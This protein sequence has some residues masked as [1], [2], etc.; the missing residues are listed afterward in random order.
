M[1]DLRYQKK[2][3][4][5]LVAISER[6]ISD[7]D[8]KLIIFQA[9]TGSGK[10]IML[11]SALSNI[12]KDLQNKKSLAFLWISVNYLHEQ[13]KE[14][15]E[16]YFE[17]ER[18][19]ECVSTN[20]IQN[21]VIEENQIVFVNWESL[22]RKGNIFMV[23]NEKDWNLSKVVENSKDEDREVVLIIDES[24][25][26]A[27]TSKAKEIINIIN[28]KLTIEVSATPK[29]GI[30][31]DHRVNVKL[32]KVIDEEMIK[33][34]IQ[35]NSGLARAE[36]N[37]DIINAA[38]RRRKRLQKQFQSA[39]TNI[40]PLLLIQIPRKKSSDVRNPEDKIIELLDKRGVTTDKGKLAI[41]LS[42]K[43]KKINLE[44]LEKNDSDVD[45]LVF[46]EAIALGWDCP[47][48]SLLLLQREWNA[49]NYVFNIQTLGR[50]MRMPEHKHYDNYPD[51]NIGY[52][53]TASDNFS[54]VE[55]LANDYVSRVQMLRDNTI[56]GNIYLPSEHIRRKREKYR[57][58]GDF[59]ECL[60]KAGKEQK[61]K[62]K[63]NTGV[64]KFKKKI[65][66][67]GY[68]EKIDQ[69][70]TIP[71]K[72]KSEIEKDREEVC[73]WYTD[74][75][76]SKTYPFTGGSRP[77]T[78][79]KSSLRALFKKVFGISNEDK[80]GMIVLNPKNKGEFEQLID[81]AKEK[82]KHLPEKKDIVNI[83]ED[84][85]VPEAISIFDNY[86]KM[87]IDNKYIKKSV[88]KPF[89][90][91]KDKNKKLRCSKPEREFIKNLEETDDDVLW[92]LK[93]GE[94]ES[95]YFGIAY[96]KDDSHYYG[97]YPDFIIQTK[98]ETLVVEIKD[99]KDFKNENL[100]KLN[101][102]KDF[103][104]KHK[105]KNLYFFIISPIDYFNF[106]RALKVQDLNS[107][108]SKYEENLLRFAQ[109]RKI[110]SIQQEEKNLEDKELLELYDDELSKAI[111]NIDDKKLE[112]EILK[113]DLENAEVTIDNLKTSLAYRPKIKDK[114]KMA[115]INI[116]KPFN[117]C[118]LGET[119][120]ND[121]V[122][123]EL[124]KYFAKYGLK[125]TEWN[126]NFYN[127]TKLKNTKVLDKLKK[128]QSKFN[129]IITGQIYFH[130]GKGNKKANLLTE[131]KK[132]KY[133]D[134]IVGCSPKKLLTINDIIKNLEEYF[135]T[136]N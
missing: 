135:I 36:N 116:P 6:Y 126:V 112:N 17:D 43:D 45:V 9:P 39:K 30:T 101:A 82:Y 3:I 10:T 121:F 2:A 44:Y 27:K 14:K 1:K 42:E 125:V 108:K 63:I 129:L 102:G 124:R 115:G 8:P 40:N 32:T 15:L 65:G 66:V 81:I 37:E 18:L 91:K 88:L 96:K 134:Y 85:Q 62:D 114:P 5:E 84:W 58:S 51:L 7:E 106:F 53:Y 123:K 19:L 73:A 98:K 71:F 132:D 76:R 78:I 127:N 75:I 22:N 24:H 31:N 94:R 21:N 87:M 35:I 38:L 83:K 26:A 72:N 67:N 25:R 11:A 12:V 20:E 103:Q 28:P 77:T 86:E 89:Y 118:I 60:L 90:V 47:R 59:K 111:K 23:D 110:T 130:S 131:L 95:K 107:F 93:N 128:G 109:S 56:Y 46:K 13:S 49:E 52:I 74:F 92:W 113:I 104:K 55:D 61:I 99:N 41:W 33:K 48:A 133:I 4:K 68:V 16:K 69:I 120:D 57:L 50:I 79:I 29:E 70:Q 54:I 100:L 64:V 122:R 34:E 136:K 80:I 119:S 117:I 105:D 97:F